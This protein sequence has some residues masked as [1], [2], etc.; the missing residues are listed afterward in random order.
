[1]RPVLFRVHPK[2]RPYFRP[3]AEFSPACGESDSK[4]IDTAKSLSIRLPRRFPPQLHSV[5]PLHKAPANLPKAEKFRGK[6]P[7]KAK[8][9][10]AKNAPQTQTANLKLPPAVPNNRSN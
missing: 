4:K 10:R 2:L 6:A 7:A 1:M 9:I 3:A 8:C 5:R